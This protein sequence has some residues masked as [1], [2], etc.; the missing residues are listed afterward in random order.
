MASPFFF[1]FNHHRLHC[2]QKIVIGTRFVQDYR[3]GHI[4]ELALNASGFIAVKVSI[5][6]EGDAG[7]ILAQLG[8]YGAGWVSGG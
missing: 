6:G 3:A 7:T 8:R 4:K 2:G 1:F 5:R